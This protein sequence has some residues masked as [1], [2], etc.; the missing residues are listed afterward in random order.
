M[1]FGTDGFL[2]E[3][4]DFFQEEDGVLVLDLR[5][6]E[7]PL[8]AGRIRAFGKVRIATGGAPKRS[9]RESRG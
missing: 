8:G 9:R 4:L 2:G 5:G 7:F 1:I 3:W 6:A